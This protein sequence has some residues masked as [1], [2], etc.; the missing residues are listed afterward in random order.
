MWEWLVL[1]SQHITTFCGMKWV[2][3]TMISQKLV[4]SL[5]Y[6]CQ[7][8]TTDISVFVPIFYAHLVVARISQFMRFEDMLETSS[9][10]GGITSIGFVPVPQTP[11]IIGKCLQ[12][13]VRLLRLYIP[14]I[15]GGEATTMINTFAPERKNCIVFPLGWDSKAP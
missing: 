14:Y 7:R 3:P 5:S 11:L 15:G 13:H 6:V 4:H 2:C 12:F 1:P 8:N 10:Q 9:S